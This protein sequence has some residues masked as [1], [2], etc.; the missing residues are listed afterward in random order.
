M[1]LDYNVLEISNLL[2][3]LAGHYPKSLLV[4]ETARFNG[5]TS[6]QQ[7]TQLSSNNRQQQQQ[8]IIYE[9]TYDANKLRDLFKKAKFAR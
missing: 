1:K 6:Q 7:P 8:Q 4:P 2:G 3:D 5:T 9:S